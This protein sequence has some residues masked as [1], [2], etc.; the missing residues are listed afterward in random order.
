MRGLPTVVGRYLSLLDAELPGVVEA[1]YISGWPTN[2]DSRP[3]PR[4]IDFVAVT[5]HTLLGRERALL[6]TLHER[7]ARAHPRPPLEGV[8]AT[9]DEL[10]SAINELPALPTLIVGQRGLQTV[11]ANPVSWLSL[12]QCDLRLRGRGPQ[13]LPI[14][15]E[16]P[17]LRAWSMSHLSG[18]WSAWLRDAHR[19]TRIAASTWRTHGVVWSVTGVGRTLYTLATGELGSKTAAMSFVRERVDGRSQQVIDEALRLRAGEPDAHYPNRAARRIDVLRF[20]S[21]A[22]RSAN[23]WAALAAPAT[24]ELRRMW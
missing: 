14:T 17:D 19:P 18:Y 13:S 24:T 7:L 6:A 22:I 15:E 4:D 23:E 21:L 8:Y 11:A 3:Q 12:K 10:S 2:G 1:V 9:W 16:L 20:V 5:Q